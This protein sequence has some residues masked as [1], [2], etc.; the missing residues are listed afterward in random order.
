MSKDADVLAYRITNAAL[1]ADYSP[2]A[3][4]KAIQDGDLPAYRHSRNGTRR[5]FRDDLIAWIK[6]EPAPSLIPPVE[7]E[8]VAD[9]RWEDEW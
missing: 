4:R 5:I 9:S 6:N 7:H 8:N 2:R 3:I 1:A